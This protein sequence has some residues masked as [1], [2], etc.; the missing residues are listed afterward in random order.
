MDKQL[1]VDYDKASS[2]SQFFTAYEKKKTELESKMAH[3]ETI[4]EEIESL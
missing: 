2:D 3:W 1:A 4:Q